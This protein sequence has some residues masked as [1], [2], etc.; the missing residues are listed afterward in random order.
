M[1]VLQWPESMGA[2]LG[3]WFLKM[4]DVL[5]FMTILY[6]HILIHF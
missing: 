6:K 2:D 3:E 4:D 5:K 1:R